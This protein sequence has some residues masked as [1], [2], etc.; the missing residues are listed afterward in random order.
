MILLNVL[1]IH[2]QSTDEHHDQWKAHADNTTLEKYSVVLTQFIQSLLL[3]YGNTSENGYKY[4]ITPSLS[5]LLATL[6]HTLQIPE[7]P[8]PV[9]LVHDIALVLFS[10]CDYSQETGD[11][12]KW[13]DPLECFI[14]IHN[15]S[16]SG[17]FKPAK[18]VTQL[19][20]ILVY[21]IRGTTL[22]EGHK[23][24]KKLG[25]DYYK[26]VFLIVYQ[27]NH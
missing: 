24:F 1:I 5:K 20:A 17:S 8:L 23:Q 18:D 22:F 9:D 14:A 25:K 19:F 16:S 10:P 26:F 12:I 11:F 3:T 7:T 4:P 15:L 27:P 21:L 6:H 2:S 13:Q